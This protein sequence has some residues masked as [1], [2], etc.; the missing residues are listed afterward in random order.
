METKKRRRGKTTTKNCKRCGSLFEVWMISV[1]AGKGLFCNAKC[2]QRYRSENSLPQALQNRAQQIKH[3][4]GLDYDDYLGMIDSQNNQC[5][6][7]GKEFD[8]TPFI[9]HCH[10]T[11]KV[12]GLLCPA[13]NTGLGVFKDDPELLQRAIEYLLA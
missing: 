3:K 10:K 12:R 13:C 4:Y 9:D 6:I 2:Y 11:G 1:R 8:K 7:C 5:F